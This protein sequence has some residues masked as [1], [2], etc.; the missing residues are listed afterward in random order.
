MSVFMQGVSKKLYRV[1]LQNEKSTKRKNGAYCN[2]ANKK[3]GG[4]NLGL[5]LKSL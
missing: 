3:K 5:L 2:V 4:K 1:C